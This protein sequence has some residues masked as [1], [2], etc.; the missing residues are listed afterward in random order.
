MLLI[1]WVQHLNLVQELK[2]Q[3]I[4]QVLLPSKTC[5][6]S[7]CDRTHLVIQRRHNYQDKFSLSFSPGRMSGNILS[8]LSEKCPIWD[9]SVSTVMNSFSLS[10]HLLVTCF[11]VVV[12]TQSAV[13][14]FIKTLLDKT[15]GGCLKGAK[16][17]QFPQLQ[18]HLRR[19]LF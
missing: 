8:A 3:K 13:P 2:S 11:P 5:L 12:Q 4:C 15:R 16:L 1:T 7:K 14:D 10:N 17:K 18:P 9:E 6:V 19:L